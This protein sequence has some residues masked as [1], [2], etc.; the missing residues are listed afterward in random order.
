M[1]PGSSEPAVTLDELL[2][3]LQEPGL[4]PAANTQAVLDAANAVVA[5]GEAS[6]A[7]PFVRTFGWVRVAPAHRGRGLGWALTEWAED[8]AA[9]RIPD[10]PE[11]AQVAIEGWCYSTQSDAIALL[12]QR[13]YTHQRTFHSMFIN[14]TEPPPAPALPSGIVICSLAQAPDTDLRTIH[15]MVRE[16]FSD[17]Y[18]FIERPM[19]EAFVE[20]EHDFSH[21]AFDPALKFLAFAGDQLVGASLCLPPAPGETEA[22]WLHQLAVRKPWRRQGLAQG[23]L[24]HTF[25]EFWQRDVARVG[26]AVDAES[27]TGATVLYEKVGMRTESASLAFRKILRPGVDLAVRTLE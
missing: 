21:K 20:W 5:Y 14:M 15:R 18:G 25:G 8:R 27:L 26:L 2:A 16:A 10:A 12:E 3:D 13:G 22:G 11:G 19:E 24:L 7:S 9:E 6:F 1:P 17:H 23:L 4:D